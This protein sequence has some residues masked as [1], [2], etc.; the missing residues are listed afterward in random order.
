MISCI[1]IVITYVI[2]YGMTALDV[3]IRYNRLGIALVLIVSVY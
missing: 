2:S 3:V 1:G